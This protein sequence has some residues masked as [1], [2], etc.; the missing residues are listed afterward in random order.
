MTLPLP[1]GL[2]PVVSVEEIRSRSDRFHCIPY[3][4]PGHPLHMLVEGCV[5]RQA[6]VRAGRKAF[7]WDRCKDCALGKEVEAKSGGPMVMENAGAIG[8]GLRPIVWKGEPKKRWSFG[9][10][11]SGGVRAYQPLPGPPKQCRVED[12]TNMRGKGAS[13]LPDADDLCISHRQKLKCELAAKRKATAA[14]SP[15][16]AYQTS[17]PPKPENEVAAFSLL[18]VNPATKTDGV[19]VVETPEQMERL[20]GWRMDAVWKNGITPVYLVGE[21]ATSE[22]PTDR[23]PP[24]VPE[25]KETKTMPTCNVAG[26]SIILRPKKLKTTPPKGTEGMCQLHREEWVSKNRQPKPPRPLKPREEIR[27]RKVKRSASWHAKR[28]ALADVGAKVVGAGTSIVADLG[29]LVQQAREFRAAI[30]RVRESI[31]GLSPESRR[32]VLAELINEE[33]QGKPA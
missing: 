4:T 20:S 8:E 12:C 2:A 9:K 19:E 6:M 28:A 11:K 3:S 30:E 25:A 22:K 5:K 1:P 32:M 7:E 18:L 14:P 24:P 17:P 13:I 33:L 16:V 27:A 10:K 21:P 15:G 26:C 23:A 31:S 29:G